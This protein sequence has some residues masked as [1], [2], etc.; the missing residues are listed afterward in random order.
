M[1]SGGLV[2]PVSGGQWQGL[3]VTS[4]GKGKWGHCNKNYYEGSQ[5]YGIPCRWDRSASNTAE[6]DTSLSRKYQ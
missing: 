5:L 6:C 4:L 1:P 3:C 2:W